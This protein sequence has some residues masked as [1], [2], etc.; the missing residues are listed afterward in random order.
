MCVLGVGV[1]EQNTQGRLALPLHA[2]AFILPPLKKCWAGNK[3]GL[4][5]YWGISLEI[6]CSISKLFGQ[7]QVSNS[8][9]S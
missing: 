7:S 1:G 3:C 4:D 8:E 5:T 2:S 9:E 6:Q